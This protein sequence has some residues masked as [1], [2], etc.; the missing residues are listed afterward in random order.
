[1]IAIINEVGLSSDSLPNKAKDLRDNRHK[2]QLFSIYP[3]P[4]GSSQ[5]S[6]STG[7]WTWGV[8]NSSHESYTSLLLTRLLQEI[9]ILVEFLK[10]K[11]FLFASES[12]KTYTI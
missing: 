2:S 4:F 11:N 6:P 9:I 1:M 7:T 3:A 10:H 5:L 12:K 8:K